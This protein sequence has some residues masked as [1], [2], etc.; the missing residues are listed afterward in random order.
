M[1][2]YTT[3][4]VTKKKKLNWKFEFEMLLDLGQGL[5]RTRVA[6]RLGPVPLGPESVE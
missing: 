3:V 4:Y 1:I 2:L 6:G 5:S